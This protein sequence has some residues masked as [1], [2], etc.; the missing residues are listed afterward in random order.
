M[1]ISK[2]WMIEAYNNVTVKNRNAVIG[3]IHF[4]IEGFTGS[5]RDG[6]NETELCQDLEKHFTE[7]R[8]G[9]IA[10]V[11]QS[12]I[13]YFLLGAGVF[14]MVLSIGGVFPWFIGLIAL[15]LSILKFV[16]GK[17]KVKQTIEDIRNSFNQ[18]QVNA[19][20]DVIREE[21]PEIE[22]DMG[23]IGI[24]SRCYLGAPYEVHMLD[25]TGSIIEHFEVY[26]AMPD[27]LEKARRLALN[28]NY[29]F[30]EVYHH[31]MRAVAENGTVA[32]LKE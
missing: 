16:L 18:S 12:P 3:D 7:I 14:A 15:A 30:I 20:L 29:A 26:R 9:R 6:S 17:K 5:T 28:G 25:V 21:L 13:D 4:E 1:A 24:V 22:I 27:G 8:D 31:E 2:D 11:K 32:T 19:L 10:A 23:P